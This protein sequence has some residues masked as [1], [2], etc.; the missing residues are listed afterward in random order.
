MFGCYARW[1]DGWRE[2]GVGWVGGKLGFGVGSRGS[3][4]EHGMEWDRQNN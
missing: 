2:G 4:L 1:G 3:R